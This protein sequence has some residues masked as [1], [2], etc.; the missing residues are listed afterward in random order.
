MTREMRNGTTLQ[1]ANEDVCSVGAKIDWTVDGDTSPDDVWYPR[2]G[3][4][5]GDFLSSDHFFRID[6]PGHPATDKQICF[7]GDFRDSIEWYSA[8]TAEF[9]RCSDYA[10]W[11]Y[12]LTAAYPNMA[13]VAP[14]NLGS[15]INAGKLANK[16]PVANAGPDQV[17]NSGALVTLSG[18]TTD[19][20]GNESTTREADNNPL[21]DSDWKW[22]RTAGP[23]VQLSFGVSGARSDIH[24]SA[25]DCP[26]RS[27][28]QS[29]GGR[30]AGHGDGREAQAREREELSRYHRYHRQPSRSVV[31]NPLTQTRER[32][33]M[34]TQVL[35]VALVLAMPI[36]STAGETDDV[37]GLSA[38][39]GAPG[40]KKEM[41]RAVEG[42]SG[43][44]ENTEKCL[45][46][47][48]L[49]EGD[50]DRLR[51]QKAYA[52]SLLAKMRSDSPTAIQALVKNID[53]SF[54][55]RLPPA[56]TWG[57]KEAVET[58]VAIG[59]PAVP[60]LVKVA[61]SDPVSYRRMC[62]RCCLVGIEGAK[63]AAILVSDASDK[64]GAVAE[65]VQ[66]AYRDFESLEQRK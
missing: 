32:R 26:D 56:D 18:K 49:K 19:A 45:V 22:T 2:S 9:E 61:V 1:R 33:C 31:L 6:Y 23:D 30:W 37:L 53:K 62:A 34:K 42:L 60:S 51:E 24:R 38:L 43:F 4:G 10:L 63:F 12:E 52:C 8:T 58:L 21:L 40:S 28:V 27:H 17:V 35:A 54:V 46:Q 7:R 13:P 36:S 14:N 25:S 65:Y 57:K 66:E 11:F 15:G 55:D 39:L 59:K 64:E 16:R 29:G 48:L 20:D 5:V 41:V 44:L 50:D 47:V 3:E